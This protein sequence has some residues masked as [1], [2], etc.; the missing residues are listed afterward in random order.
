MKK[1]YNKQGIKIQWHSGDFALLCA[2]KGKVHTFHLQ[3]YMPSMYFKSHLGP[4]LY[5][6]AL[7]QFRIFW[8]RSYKGGVLR[9]FGFG[10][11][12]V[13]ERAELVGRVRYEG[14]APRST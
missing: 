13:L 10:G 2:K 8:S 4:G 14:K 11:G 7:S 12:I 1:L 9:L 3:L 5:L 6:D